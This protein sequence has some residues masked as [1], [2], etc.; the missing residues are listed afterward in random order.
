MMRMSRAALALTAAATAALVLAS[1][2]GAARSAPA[3]AGNPLAATSSAQLAGTLGR[4]LAAARKVKIKTT[5]RRPGGQLEADITWSGKGP[6]RARIFGTV[7]DL[8]PDGHCVVAYV[9]GDGASRLLPER[10]CPS[11]DAGLVKYTFRRV[12]RALV[13]VCLVSP[14]EGTRYCS[15]WS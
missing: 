8:E 12:W 11:G 15:A 2:A 5:D 3:A 4:P 1:T 13:K 7:Q 14:N 10:A 9:W 6:F